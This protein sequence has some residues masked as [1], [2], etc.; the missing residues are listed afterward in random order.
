MDL[1]RRAGIG[2]A[3]ALLG[4][5]AVAAQ[6]EPDEPGTRASARARP[7]ATASLRYSPTFTLERVA[8]R[9][10]VTLRPDIPAPAIF[11]ESSTPLRQFQD[12]IAA[13]WGF[14]PRVFGNAYALARNEIYLIDD[15]ALYARLG[16]T[17][18]ESLAHEFVHYL[19]V[20]YQK[21]DLADPSCESDAIAVQLWYRDAIVTPSH[22][23]ADRQAAPRR[24]HPL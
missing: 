2:V 19:Q 1:M 17:L 20:R 16:G 15:P 8:Q 12:A 9:L 22:D 7:A 24:A 11:F 5:T 4:L 10:G 14:R 23:L 13:Q 21:A 3:T 6:A 18:D